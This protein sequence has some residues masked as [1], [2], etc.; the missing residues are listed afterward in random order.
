MFVFFLLFYIHA[1]H[2]GVELKEGGEV[3]EKWRKPPVEPQTKVY[4][5]NVTNPVEFMKGQ[6]PIFK[7]I[8]PYVY[9]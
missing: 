4:F 9:K 6:K 1:F 3:F 5:F 7:Q 8:G 2:V